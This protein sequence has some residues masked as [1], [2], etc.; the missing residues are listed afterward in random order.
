MRPCLSA[1][2][3]APNTSCRQPCS[4]GMSG[5]SSAG[6]A[7][8]VLAGGD[9]LGGDVVLLAFGGEQDF[10]QRDQ[11]RRGARAVAAV[12]SGGQGIRRAAPWPRPWR[13]A[14]WRRCGLRR[15][16]GV[17]PRARASCSGGLGGGGGDFQQRLVLEHAVARNIGALRLA[18]APGGDGAQHGEHAAVA[19]ARAQ[20][21]PHQRRDRGGRWPGRRAPP[22]PRPPSR[23]GRPFPVGR[24]G[25][26]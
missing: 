25:C 22:F 11:G 8:D 16:R 3:S 26:S 14:G 5:A 12:E 15:S 4:T 10:Q 20:P 7:V 9:Q 2:A 18:L 19:G 1:W 24:A 13:R 21:L 17:T 6:Q 23:A